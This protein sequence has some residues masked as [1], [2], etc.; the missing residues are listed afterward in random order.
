MLGGTANTLEGKDA[1]SVRGLEGMLLAVRGMTDDQI[2]SWLL[3]SEG[4][5]KRHPTIDAKLGMSSSG[6]DTARMPS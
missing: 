1:S 4:K 2:A 6:A 3:I 5:V